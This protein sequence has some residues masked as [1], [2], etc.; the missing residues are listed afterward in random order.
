MLLATSDYLAQVNPA[1]IGKLTG[2]HNYATTI[3]SSFI[4]SGSAGNIS[5][6]IAG[7]SVDFDTGIIDQ[8]TLDILVADQAW[9]IGFAGSVNNGAVNLN[10]TSGQLLD[11]TGIISNAIDA[12]LGGVFTGDTGSAFVGGFDLIDQINSVHSVNGLFT[13]ER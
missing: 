11:S 6:L 12:N 10:A 1:P 5:S 2:S 9:S 13:L 3:L 8:G 7:M 4:G